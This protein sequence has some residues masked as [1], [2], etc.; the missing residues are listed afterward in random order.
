[1]TNDKQGPQLRGPSA[2]CGGYYLRAIG[3]QISDGAIPCKR[4][5]CDNPA[6]GPAKLKYYYAIFCNGLGVKEGQ[7]IPE[8]HDV[9][10][11]TVTTDPKKWDNVGL[12]WDSVGYSFRL[13]R[14]RIRLHYGKFDYIAVLEATKAGWPHLHVVCKNIPKIPQGWHEEYYDRDKRQWIV[15]EK[16]SDKDGRKWRIIRPKSSDGRPT[17]SEMADASGFGEVCDVRAV[18]FDNAKGAANYLLG[19]LQKSLNSTKYP[20]NTRRVRYTPGWLNDDWVRPNKSNGTGLIVPIEEELKVL[21]HYVERVSGGEYDAETV[22]SFLNAIGP[23]KA[24]KM[25]FQGIPLDF[26]ANI[27]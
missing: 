3:G 19:Y 7:S 16:Q 13:L 23:R 4:W 25:L 18:K 26:D 12:A 22:I 8:G 20:R 11:I 2:V 14:Q 5:D 9:T 17:L 10:L 21:R 24:A 27:D 6:C 1:V 15:V